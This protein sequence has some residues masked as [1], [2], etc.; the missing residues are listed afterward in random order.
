M[1]FNIHNPSLDHRD[2][3][4]CA[5]LLPRNFNEADLGGGDRDH[6][7]EL[8]RSLSYEVDLLLTVFLFVVL[9]AS[10]DVLMSV[11]QHSVDQSG[12]PMRHGSNGFRGAEF[13]AQPSVLCTQVGTTFQ[14]GVSGYAQ[15]PRSPV[16]YAPRSSS[17][18]PYLH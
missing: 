8:G 4:A 11:L 3:G 7:P 2:R 9:C 18:A 1:L 16:D 5:F 10:V 14:E 15:R 13:G 17:S 6:E 12:K